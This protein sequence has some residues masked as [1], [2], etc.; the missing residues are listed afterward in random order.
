[1]PDKAKARPNG[2]E[3]YAVLDTPAEPQFDDLTLLATRVCGVPYG[4]INLAEPHRFWV[5]SRVGMDLT[6]VPRSQAFCDEV[7]RNPS[8][9]LVVPDLTA[10]RRF[11]TNPFVTDGP[12]VRFYAGVPL[13]TPDGHAVGTLCVL[14]ARPRHLDDRQREALAAIARQ[15]VGQLELRRVA[16]ENTRLCNEALHTARLAQHAAFHDALTGLPNRVNFCDRVAQCISLASDDATY[17]FAVLSVDLD[18]FK[19]TNDSLGH[20]AGDLLLSTVASRMSACLNELPETASAHTLARFGSDEFMVL[21]DE[22][23]S[24]DVAATVAIRLL[25]ALSRPFHLGESIIHPSGS[26]GVVLGDG[27]YSKAEDLA[28]DADAALTQAKLSGRAQ[29]AVFDSKMHQRSVDR[30]LLE[31]E[32]RLAI[33]RSQLL[34]HYQPVVSLKDQSLMGFEAL[35]R[36]SNGG[37]LVSPGDFIPVAEETGLIV[38]IGR[39]VLTEAVRQLAEW[40]RDYPDRPL[41]KMAVNLSRRQ[42]HDPQLVPLVRRL[43]RTHKLDPKLLM[44]EITESVVMDDAEAA[45]QVLERLRELGV[46]LAMDDFGTGYSSLSCLHAFPIDVLKVDRSF[47]ANLEH[48]REAAVLRAMLDLS[49]TLGLTVVAEGIETAQQ[50][51]FLRQAACDYGQGYFFARPLNAE[52]AEKFL[53]GPDASSMSVAA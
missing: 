1:M 49:H 47:V 6:E 27:N 13:T 51:A 46:R 7:M 32:L 4:M 25:A 36:W 15:V 42:L 44:L 8:R 31:N 9:P 40:K 10:D 43:L 38:P 18:R 20:D 45:G 16:I 29:V 23:A 33:E 30:L 34:L 19:L 11:A 41:S 21:I 39:W 37:K 24:V 22:V 52:A 35:V 48:G 53:A 28:R 17:R 5:K 26:V 12:K 3:Q 50:M 14:D 2:L